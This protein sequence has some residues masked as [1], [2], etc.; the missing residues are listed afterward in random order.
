M[1]IR[2][3]CILPL[4]FNLS[5][6]LPKMKAILSD[7][8]LILSL[9][10]RLFLRMFLHLFLLTMALWSCYAHS[11]VMKVIYLSG[12]IPNDTRSDDVIEML[13]TALEK[14]VP[15]YGPYEL[16]QNPEI[17]PKNRYLLDLENGHPGI[18]V[19]WNSTSEDMERRFLPIRI[20]LRKG[21]LGYR[22]GLI[23]KAKQSKFDQV[24]TLEDLKRLSIVI[25]QGTGWND[26]LVYEAAGI[27]LTKGRYAQLFK[28][29]S[30]NR[31]DLF[32]RGVG[33]IYPELQQNS[34]ENPDLVVEKNLLIIYPFPFY[35]FF[36]HKDQA[37]KERV[38]VG[39][40]IMQKDGSFDAIFNKYH[41]AA[42]EKANLKGRRVIRLNN[43]LLP[44]NTP[45]D[46]SSLWYDP[47]K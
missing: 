15:K 18:S 26:N 20:P 4:Y 13:R 7:L 25:G 8:S 44:K 27:T 12:D 45:L 10:L 19:V 30:A 11:E 1:A 42:I 5:T 37:I 3:D 38:E 36:N 9:F 33:E 23:N 39:L 43:P 2:V 46:D 6:L 24:K 47:P 40:R 29:L 17:M 34:A 35:F 22:I 28:M 21:L 14:T 31:F 32:P 16:T 41:H